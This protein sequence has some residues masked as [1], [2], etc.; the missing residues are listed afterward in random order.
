MPSRTRWKWGILFGGDNLSMVDLLRYGKMADDAGADSVWTAEVWRDA[1]VPLTAM[2]SVVQRAR[3][4]TA[5][6]QFARSPWHTEMSAMSVAEYTGGRFVLGVGTAPP[7][8]NEKWHGLPY[9][10]P[11]TRMREYIECIRT[12][13]TST[14]TRPVHYAGEFFHVQDYARFM[15]APYAQLPIYLA[16]VQARMLQLAGSHADGWI[17]GPLNTLKYLTEGG[18]AQLAEGHGGGEAHRHRVR[19]LRHE[20]V[21]D[22]SGRQVR[23]ALGAQCYRLICHPALLRYCAAAHGVYSTHTGDSR[24]DAT[25]GHPWDAERG[26][27]GDD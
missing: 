3:V 12:M 11:V 27:R 16:A 7:E 19:A 8:W 9:R 13:W 14:P 20:A 15:P 23:A 18:P 24:R 21:R 1:F 4:G 17:S 10:K 25:P 6:A 22:P 5:I 26:D 2:A